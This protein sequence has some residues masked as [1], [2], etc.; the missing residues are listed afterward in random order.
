MI[1]VRGAISTLVDHIKEELAATIKSPLSIYFDTNPYDGLLENH[2]VDKSL[3][4]KL[5]SLIFI[6]ILSQTYCDQE[7]FAWR[8]EFCAFN[9]FAR[10]DK[11]GIDVKLNNGNIAS[12]VLPIKIHDLDVEDVDLIETEIGRTLRA[13]DFIFR[14]AGV[15]RPLQID[16]RRGQNH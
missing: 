3:A 4:R 6:P 9:D 11:L 2:D 15:N 12:R 8:N 5:R 7:S 1:I 13:I 16:D 14:S 10:G